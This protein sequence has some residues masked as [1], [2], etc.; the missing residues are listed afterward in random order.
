MMNSPGQYIMCHIYIYSVNQLFII[1]HKLHGASPHQHIQ[2]HFVCWGKFSVLIIIVLG[3]FRTYLNL[4]E[5]IS[6]F[7]NISKPI[8][9]YKNIKGV[10]KKTLHKDFNYFCFEIPLYDKKKHQFKYLYDKIYTI[11]YYSGFYS[12]LRDNIWASAGHL[13][14]CAWRWG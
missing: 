3:P 2:Y 1:C 4:L 14:F 6:T 9:T 13:K 5:A 7:Q 12:S 10:P 11:G 8:R